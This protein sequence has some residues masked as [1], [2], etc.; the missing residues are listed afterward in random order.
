[1]KNR[2]I[3]QSDTVSDRQT[4]CFDALTYRRH[5]LVSQQPDKDYANYI[6][7]E[8]LEHVIDVT[9]NIYKE[10]IDIIK[11]KGLKKVYDIGCAYGHNSVWFKAN[12]LEYIGIEESKLNFYNKANIRYIQR[13]YPFKIARVTTTDIAISVLA[14]GWGC[15]DYTEGREFEA[16]LKQLAEDFSHIILY[17]PKEKHNLVAYYFEI[18]SSGDLCYGYNKRKGYSNI[19]P[20]ALEIRGSEK[21]DT[22]EYLLNKKK[23]ETFIYDLR[24]IGLKKGDIND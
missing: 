20:K 24:K 9:S 17:L 1:M 10:I 14:L 11:E 19:R 5:Y 21:T 8:A 12:C 2:S 4:A 18:E 3:I 13:S 16:Q 7:A 15:Y 6:E 23:S 22:K